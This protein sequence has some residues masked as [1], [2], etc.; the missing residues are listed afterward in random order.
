MYTWIYINGC[1]CVDNH[2]IYELHIISMSFYLSIFINCFSNIILTR[3]FINFFNRPV[4]LPISSPLPINLED[5]QEF[6]AHK[7]ISMLSGLLAAS[8]KSGCDNSNCV[9]L[10]IYLPN[11][12]SM[13]IDIAEMSNFKDIVKSIFDA[14]KSE[15]LEPALYY[16]APEFY[17][18][19]MHEGIHIC[20]FMFVF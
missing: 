9:Q 12:E 14:H 17:V 8:L 6:I 11:Y 15:K 19:R 20:V 3:I 1:I 16:Y 10:T 18:M 2:V 4:P 5:N 7:N 13:N